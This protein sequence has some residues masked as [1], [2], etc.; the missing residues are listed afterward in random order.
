[1]LL[2]LGADDLPAGHSHIYANNTLVLQI[3]RNSDHITSVLTNAFMHMHS[4][5]H[6]EQ[7]LL[8]YSSAVDLYLSNTPAKLKATLKNI[9]HLDTDDAH[10]LI[11]AALHID[12]LLP[13][14]DAHGQQTLSVGGLKKMTLPLLHQLAQSKLVHITSTMS[15]DTVVEKL[16][17][18]FYLKDPDADM[19]K[20]EM[21]LP[22]Y[23]TKPEVHAAHVHSPTS[24]SSDVTTFYGEHYGHIYQLNCELFS[25][26]WPAGQNNYKTLQ[27]LQ[28]MAFLVLNAQAAHEEL[29]FAAL[30]PCQ[31]GSAAPHTNTLHEKSLSF[32]L[33]LVEEI[34]A[35]QM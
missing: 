8:A 2:K 4:A 35:E 32:V 20:G 25:I 24:T 29:K 7:P 3:T 5:L 28:T 21:Q 15:K 22:H 23:R 9:D 6:P 31:P 18:C 27:L 1:M 13:V 34:L 10:V 19:H 30:L 11:K 16:S 17:E 12:P 14:P 26:N 33:G